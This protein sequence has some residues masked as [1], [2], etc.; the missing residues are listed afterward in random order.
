MAN[1]QLC[2][3][4]FYYSLKKKKSLS[5]RSIP[6]LKKDKS[7]EELIFYF[8]CV[9]VFV[10]TCR[11]P[12]VKVRRHHSGVSSSSRL[13]RQCPACC[14]CCV[15]VLRLAGTSALDLFS[16]VHLISHH[17]NAGIAEAWHHIQLFMWDPGNK[18]QLLGWLGTQLAAEPCPGYVKYS[19]ADFVLT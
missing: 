18:I 13:S 1:F 12:G 17:G 5:I 15:Y 7:Y 3:I 14:V 11:L 9:Q 16:C 10:H 2:G 8:V 4:S 6:S 19:Y